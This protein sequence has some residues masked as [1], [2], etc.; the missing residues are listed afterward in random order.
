ML[1]GNSE[2]TVEKQ[3]PY[4]HSQFFQRCE[5]FELNATESSKRALFLTFNDFKDKLSIFIPSE[6]TRLML[7]TV[8]VPLI[9]IHFEHYFQD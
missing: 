1:S 8:N 3:Q 2:S 6:S 9:S 5:T 7:F 4:F